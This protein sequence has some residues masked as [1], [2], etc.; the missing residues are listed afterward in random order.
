MFTS[1]KVR[2]NSLKQMNVPKP[3]SMQMHGKI[4]ASKREMRMLSENCAN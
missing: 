2:P 4:S 3:R 1:A